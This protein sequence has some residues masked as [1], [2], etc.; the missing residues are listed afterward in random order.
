MP[1]CYRTCPPG[2]KRRPMDDYESRI[3]IIRTTIRSCLDSDEED[4]DFFSAS[5]CGEGSPPRWRDARELENKDGNKLSAADSTAARGTSSIAITVDATLA[6]GGRGK[7]AESYAL[8]HAHHEHGPTSQTGKMNRLGSTSNRTLMSGG[9]PHHINN[10][11]SDKSRLICN[12]R[13]TTVE[14]EPNSGIVGRG[15]ASNTSNE[16]AAA[17]PLTAATSHEPC[18]I[19][20]FAGMSV[21]GLQLLAKVSVTMQTLGNLCAVFYARKSLSGSWFLKGSASR[22][23]RARN[24]SFYHRARRQQQR[25]Q[26]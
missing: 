8:L 26:Y 3:N 23:L 24:V 7:A 10:A 1:P 6:G 22:Q 21:S 2:T 5:D 20:S 12:R 19:L 18:G 4:E 17:H 11:T 16:S 25:R 9:Q 15:S 14:P 13:E